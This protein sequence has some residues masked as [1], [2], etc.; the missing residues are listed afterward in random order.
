MQK[1]KQSALEVS[2]QKEPLKFRRI[3]QRKLPRS[4]SLS[5]SNLPCFKEMHTNLFL[6]DFLLDP[7]HWIVNGVAVSGNGQISLDFKP[8][9]SLWIVNGDVIFGGIIS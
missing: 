5:L 4:L 9:I 8:A 3:M 1:T 6:L 2:P 7:S